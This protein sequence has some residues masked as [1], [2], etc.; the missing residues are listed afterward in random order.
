MKPL[1]HSRN[2]E[3]RDGEIIDSFMDGQVR[4]IQS[5]SGYRFSIDAVFLAEFATVKKD[6]VIVELGTGCG[7]ILLLLL[8]KEE[9]KHA[10]GIEIQE[11]LASQ[12]IRNAMLNQ[13]SNRM[14]VIMADLR[15]CPLMPRCADLVIC[16]PPYRKPKSGRLNPDMQKAIARHEIM[17]CLQDVL[18][19]TRSILRPKGR[20]AI[21][22]PA[23]RLAHVISQLRKFQLEPKRIRIQYPALE[24]EAKLVLVEAV[25]GGRPG[26]NI[27]APLVGQG[28][29][30]II[31][32]G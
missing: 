26:L 30:S 20:L 31:P 17:A 28:D 24:A 14:S 1:N 3:L 4:L 18:R 32:H 13:L 5:K 21:V 8:T 7:I 23:E 9:I 10:I 6:D 25:L 15:S 16:N 12:A 2:I 29:Y 11:E 22:Y 19:T 27:E